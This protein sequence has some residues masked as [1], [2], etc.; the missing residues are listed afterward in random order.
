MLNITQEQSFTESQNRSQES[1]SRKDILKE[2]LEIVLLVTLFIP[3]R[4]VLV[5]LPPVSDLK[6]RIIPDILIVYVSCRERQP[7][8]VWKTNLSTFHLKCN[9]ETNSIDCNE[10]VPMLTFLIQNYD[11]PRAYKYIFLHAHETAWHHSRPA[12][13]QVHE[14]ISLDYFRRNQF[15]AVFPVYIEGHGNMMSKQMYH[16]IYANTTMPPTPI[17]KNNFRPCCATF[18]VDSNL[19][20]TRAKSEY[21]LI[22]T[23]LRHWSQKYPSH[24]R[25]NAAFFCGRVMEYTWHLLLA[26][27]SD[28]PKM[29]VPTR[30]IMP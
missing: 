29:P 17:S 27:Q 14:L 13:D 12:F 26:N 2:L 9:P 16:D 18:F 5:G 7:F 15:G 24:A 1:Y 4:Q 11:H 30:Q 6:I 20:Q 28:I 3:S 23:R 21:E 19:I 10:A 25:R 22:R 8:P